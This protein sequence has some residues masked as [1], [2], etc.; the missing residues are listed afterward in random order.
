[1]RY[2]DNKFPDNY[3]ATIGID[4]RI[5]SF[6]LNGQIIK[7]QI[8]DTAGQDRFKNIIKSY[9]KGAHGVIFVYDVTDPASFDNLEDWNFMVKEHAPENI[10][11]VLFGKHQILI[12]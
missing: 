7:L 6:T 11:K 12:P 9:Y 1:M 10:K 2:T 8:W 3:M 4:F 5:K